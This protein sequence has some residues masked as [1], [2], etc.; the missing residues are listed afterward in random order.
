MWLQFQPY[1]LFCLSRRVTLHCTTKR[2]GQ[3]AYARECRLYA[4]CYCHVRACVRACVVLQ[5]R[6]RLSRFI[7]EI[8]IFAII[9]RMI[10]VEDV[11]YLIVVGAHQH[12]QQNDTCVVFQ[13]N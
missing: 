11:V 5:T 8:L 10:R 2:N 13:G 4:L 7:G 12:Q 1:A 6:P 3:H 9:S